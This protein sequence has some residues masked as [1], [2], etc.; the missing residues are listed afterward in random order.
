MREGLMVNRG[1]RPHW[2][3]DVCSDLLLSKSTGSSSP[4]DAAVSTRSIHRWSAD[5]TLTEGQRSGGVALS[6]LELVTN[7]M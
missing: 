5:L 3:G 6:Q 2:L 1:F 7:K 4:D